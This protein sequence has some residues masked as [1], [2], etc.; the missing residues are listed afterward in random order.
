[1]LPSIEH[2]IFIPGVFLLG[3]AVGYVTGGKAVR[4]EL[5]RK[6]EARKR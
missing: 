4:E 3:L 2:V 1:M 5:R 6:Q